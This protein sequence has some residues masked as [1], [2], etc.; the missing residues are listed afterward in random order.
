MVDD[1]Q[2]EFTSVHTLRGSEAKAI[3]KWRTDGWELD[4]RDQ[5]LLRTEL[6]FR[7]VKPTTLASRARMAFGRLQPKAQLSVMAGAGVLVL[8]VIGGGVV[9]G[10]QAGGDTPTLAASATEAAT[11]AEPSEKPSEAAVR[12]PAATT[13]AVPTTPLPAPTTAALAP[14]APKPQPVAPKPPAPAPV[15]PKAPAPAPAPAPQ[16]VAPPVANPPASTHFKNC[17]AARAAGAA[18]VRIGDPG[19]GR[20][21]D[22]EG[23]GVGCE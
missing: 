15:V 13:S 4:S 9:A 17:D 21:L 1:V 2:Y 18:P 10:I 12:A 23:D 14:E 22:R 20:H 11:D 3:A 6:T 5:G 16:V 19:Y 7:R 8:C